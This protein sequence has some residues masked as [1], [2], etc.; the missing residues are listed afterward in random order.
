M[1]GQQT[2]YIARPLPTLDDG[3]KYLIAAGSTARPFITK[4]AYQGVNKLKVPLIVTEGPV[5]SLVLAQAGFAGVGLNGVRC[6]HQVLTGGKLAL[7]NELAE[8]GLRGRKVYICFDADAASKPDVRHGSI[9]LFFLL[10]SAGAEPYQLTSWDESQGKGVDDFLVAELQDDPSQTA[11]AILE[12]LVTDAQLFLETFSKAKID[13]DAVESELEKV[14]LGALHRDQLCRQ[15]HRPLGVKVEMLRAIGAEPEAVGRR[16]S[17]PEVDPWPEEVSGDSLVQD[18]MEIIRKHVVLGDY[19]V[20]TAALWSLLCWFVNSDRI[21][22]LPFLTL[23][24]PDKRCGKTRF[25]TVLEW[26][27]PRPLSTSNISSAAV[28]RT[29][30]AH[31]PTLLMDEVDTCA[32]ENEELRGVLNAGHT[33]EKAFVIRCH[34]TTLEPERFNVWCPK[35]FA[36]IGDLPS[37]L[38]DRSVVVAMERKKRAEKVKPLRATEAQER[39]EIKRRIVRW[40]QD[41]ADKMEVLDAPTAE[42]ISDRDADNWLPLLQ[43]AK[44]LGSKWYNDAL[45]AMCKLNPSDAEREDQKNP[46]ISLLVRLQR[47]L[48]A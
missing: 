23:A 41:N 21:D 28:Y 4:L 39:E 46:T 30:E 45:K 12:L 37:T 34:P 10:A 38:M 5:K 47:I 20:F 26:F 9:R 29:I 22:T 13:L 2:G 14:A 11:Q 6:A 17:F 33:R 18:M 7:R 43:V 36:L 24:S 44:L 8:L 16:I 31:H 42:Q 27:V 40:Y 48:S 35:C 15:L 25:Q 3:R 32:R 19:G 1:R